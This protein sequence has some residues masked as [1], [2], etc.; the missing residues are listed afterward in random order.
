MLWQAQERYPDVTFAPLRG[1][2]AHA[3]VERYSPTLLCTTRCGR[4]GFV[5]DLVVEVDAVFP[6]CL[7]CAARLA[8]NQDSA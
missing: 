8:D 1:A 3:I 6:V 7:Q 5:E 2:V 4:L